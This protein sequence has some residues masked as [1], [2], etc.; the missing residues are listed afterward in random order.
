LDELEMR[1]GLHREMWRL[2]GSEASF[3]LVGVALVLVGVID[4]LVGSTDP[5]YLLFALVGLVLIVLAGCRAM[6]ELNRLKYDGVQLRLDYRGV[7]VAYGDRGED[8]FAHT[9][10]DNVAA[11]VVRDL[12]S[13]TDKTHGECVE[14]V[15][16][17]ADL[18]DG[19]P[20]RVLE[21]AR[22]LG[23]GPAVALLTWAVTPHHGLRADPVIAWVREHHP[24][25]RLE[26]LRGR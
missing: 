5:I 1:G 8:L 24:V 11:V 26:D 21:T 22:A 19:D 9:T 6:T 25:I 4:L 20:T 7:Y 23:V 2:F 3:A 16:L 13:F 10:W 18:V 17:K 14:F 12:P 15:P